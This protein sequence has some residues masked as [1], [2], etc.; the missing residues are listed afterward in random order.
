[1]VLPEKHKE[2]MVKM[3]DTAMSAHQKYSIMT[4]LLIRRMSKNK[5][6]TSLEDKVMVIN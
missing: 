3:V 6:E 1:M 4:N 5:K 2:P